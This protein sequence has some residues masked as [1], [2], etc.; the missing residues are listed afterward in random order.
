M[1]RYEVTVV[2]TAG[3][4]TFEVEAK[5]TSDAR[6]VAQENCRYASVRITGIRP[7]GDVVR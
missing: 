6:K 5:S 4:S 1:K 3:A 2:G 7:V